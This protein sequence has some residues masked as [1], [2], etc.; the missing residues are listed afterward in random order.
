MNDFSILNILGWYT[1]YGIDVGFG[2]SN[3]DSGKSGE[4]NVNDKFVETKVPVYGSN[5]I[6][7]EQLVFLI[8]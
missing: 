3:I 1:G 6:E 5:T 8:R 2:A 7:D 4:E